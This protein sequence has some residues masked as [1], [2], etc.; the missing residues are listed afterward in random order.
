MHFHNR[1]SLFPDDPS[2]AKMTEKGGVGEGKE[3]EKE[4]K[5]RKEEKEKRE[6][7][8]KQYSRLT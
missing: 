6:K 4:E 7:K 8:R 3:E 1:G 5:E 2:C